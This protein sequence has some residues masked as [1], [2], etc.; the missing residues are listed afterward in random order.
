MRRRAFTLIELL[1]VVA[2]IAMLIAILLPS[3]NRAREAARR[4]V[5]GGNLRQNLVGAFAF[6]TDHQM[7]LPFLGQ[8][9][10]DNNGVTYFMFEPP[11]KQPVN[12]GLLI[13]YGVG[14]WHKD[15]IMRCPSA[16]PGIWGSVEANGNEYLMDS[17]GD[18][19]HGNYYLWE[20][21]N[22]WVN[23]RA[24]Y[25]RRPLPGDTDYQG[26]MLSTQRG[27]TAIMSDNITGG[28]RVLGGHSDGVNASYLDGSTAYVLDESPP[29]LA[30]PTR[31]MTR[32]P[33]VWSYL[34]SQ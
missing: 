26:A 25:T 15:Q 32:I 34:D 21:R 33:A 28:G 7:R 1:V 3:M 5:C 14:D 31:N 13:E 20:A 9:A 8:N 23:L 2:I 16:K 30:D 22:T 10:T 17:A 12:F 29:L 24:W 27:H 6:A 4:I 18:P 11:T 19:S